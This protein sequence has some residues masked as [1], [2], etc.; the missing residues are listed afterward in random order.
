MDQTSRIFAAAAGQD[1]PFATTKFANMLVDPY[2]TNDITVYGNTVVV[3]GD[4]NDNI[5]GVPANLCYSTDGGTTW[6][7]KSL[8]DPSASN[9]PY[10]F[11]SVTVNTATGQ[12]FVL[13]KSQFGSVTL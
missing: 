4:F 7:S 11:S 3:V 2:S 1:Q 5:V 12:F 13:G 8:T 6:E 9:Q 10:S